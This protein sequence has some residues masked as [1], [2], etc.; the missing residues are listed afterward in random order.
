MDNKQSTGN[1]PN[2]CYVTFVTF[3]YV[4]EIKKKKNTFPR[5]TCFFHFHGLPEE[6]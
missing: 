6:A 2:K 4:T 5:E 1:I 3:G